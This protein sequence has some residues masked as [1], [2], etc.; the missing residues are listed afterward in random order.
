MSSAAELLG[1]ERLVPLP[2]VPAFLTRWSRAV[3]PL[4]IPHL[5][6]FL[7]VDPAKVKLGGS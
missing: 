5:E 4:A 6:V 3:L 2:T 7:A 1:L